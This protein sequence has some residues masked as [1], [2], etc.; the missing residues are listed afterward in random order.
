MLHVIKK[1]G[2]KTDLVCIAIW[3]GIIWWLQQEYLGLGPQVL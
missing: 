1:K 3:V 2:Y